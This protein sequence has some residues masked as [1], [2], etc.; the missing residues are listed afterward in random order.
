MMKN[1]E[2]CGGPKR[3]MTSVIAF[4]FVLGCAPSLPQVRFESVPMRNL[5]SADGE[6]RS[7]NERFP[8]LTTLEDFQEFDRVPVEVLSREVTKAGM[9]GAEKVKVHLLGRKEDLT[10][11]VKVFPRQLD[12]FNNS[13]R[14]ELATYAIQHFF[15]DPADYVVPTTGVQCIP[16]DDW[17]RHH[18]GQS[19]VVVP[20]TKCTLVS[21]AFWLENVKLPDAIFDKDR[22]LSD[23]LYAYHLAHYNLLTY[24]VGHHDQRRGNV[25]VSE[26]DQ[27]RRVF[28]I[29]NG[30]SFDPFLFNWFYPPTFMWREVRVPAIPR[31]T[32]ER[33]RSLDRKDLESLHVVVQLT[34]DE[35]GILRVEAPEAAIEKDEG[36]SVRGT[37]VQLG[38]TRD[39][40]ED[41]WERIEDLLKDVDAGQIGLF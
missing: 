2:A 17:K 28:S 20:G 24:L 19:M 18:P 41:V 7:L 37:T 40:V 9:T 36:V 21:Y 5:E 4:F 27:D 25:L 35:K 33:L 30:V 26:D 16:V 1:V 3:V 8:P 22:F 12:G 15:L 29:D 11:K 14:R 13:P 39:E 31:K 23:P 34:G 6:G 32:I 38:L 10:L